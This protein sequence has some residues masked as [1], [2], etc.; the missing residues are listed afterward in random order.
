M[1]ARLT[2]A[3]RRAAEHPPSRRVLV[4][5]HCGIIRAAIP[6][7]C[8]GTPAPAIDL[9]NCQIVELQ[10]LL[11]SNGSGVSATLTHWP[12]TLPDAREPIR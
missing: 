4:V 9:R 5:A 10:L 12:L 3:L 7:I 1:T 2:A 8:P 6:A 11:A